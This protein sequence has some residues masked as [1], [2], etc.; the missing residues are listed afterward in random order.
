MSDD[1]IMQCPMCL[2]E[3]KY[4]IQ[5]LS[6]N[7]NC[8]IPGNFDSFKS[9]FGVYKQ[10]YQQN[11]KRENKVVSRKKLRE[12]DNEKV[13]EQQRNHKETSMKNLREQDNE[14]VKEEQR[15]RKKKQHVKL[16][17]AGQ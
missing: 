17:S 3:T 9:Q 14:K 12:E 16:K 8:Q 11:R 2:K 5:H 6:K 15:N 7:K 4:I 13:K 10:K 1:Y